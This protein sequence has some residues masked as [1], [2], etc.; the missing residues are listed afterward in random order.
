[1]SKRIVAEC[2]QPQAVLPMH[3]ATP[4]KWMS[5]SHEADPGGGG[6]QWCTP[7]MMQV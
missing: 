4:S 1:M 5:N 2:T 3:D 7:R 6:M